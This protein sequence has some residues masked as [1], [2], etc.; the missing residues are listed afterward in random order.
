MPPNADLMHWSPPPFTTG[1]IQLQSEGVNSNISSHGSRSITN[2]DGQRKMLSLGGLQVAAEHIESSEPAVIVYIGD[3]TE[4]MVDIML[5][6]SSSHV[7][8]YSPVERITCKVLGSCSKPFHERYGGVA[9]VK[10][11]QII[12]LLVG[13]MGLTATLIQRLLDRLQ[14]LILAANKRY[15]TFVMGRLNE[16]K[17]CNFPE[18]DVYCFI[19]NHDTARIPPKTFHAPVIT[20]FELELGLGSQEWSSMYSTDY[21]MK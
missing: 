20:P 2:D 21:G 9:K 19:S 17:L 11:S 4:Q 15:Y 1:R 3:K 18:V 8:H 16:A 14:T 12:G 13:S 5:R 7:I 6:L 10:E